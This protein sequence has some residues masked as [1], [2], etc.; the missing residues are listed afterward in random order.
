MASNRRDKRLLIK[1]ATIVSIDRRCQRLGHSL[2]SGS[3]LTS[4]Y[5]QTL[6][7]GLLH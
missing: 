4:K 2:P 5:V 7:D 6:E 3:L 1:Y